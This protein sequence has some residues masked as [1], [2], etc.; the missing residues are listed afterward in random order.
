MQLCV[1]QNIDS[2][3]VQ[4]EFSYEVGEWLAISHNEAHWLVS[5]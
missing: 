3:A 5:S 2:I 4:Q 1:S